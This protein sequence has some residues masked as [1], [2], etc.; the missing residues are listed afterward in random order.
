[1]SGKGIEKLTQAGINITVGVLE[2]EC[3]ALNKRFFT[4]HN[5]LRP[6]IILKWAQSS[7][8]KITG[9]NSSRM[10][11][12]NETSN[13]LVH[14][15]RGEEAAILVGTNTALN[16]DPALTARLWP[17]KDPVRGVI[18]KELKLPAHLK[19][20]DGSTETIVFNYLKK[21]ITA[22]CITCN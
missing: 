9:N 21:K 19:L 6:Y 16:D 13:R 18:D 17:G 7:D 22:S 1:M 11:I 3:L 10:L 15:W 12:S 2:K 4:F 5:Q 14:K 20:F 8:G